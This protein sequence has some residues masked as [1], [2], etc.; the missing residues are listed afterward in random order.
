M[1]LIESEAG[2]WYVPMPEIS[3]AKQQT[4][5]IREYNHVKMSLMSIFCKS[6]KH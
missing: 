3:V 1:Q 5:T 4:H 6:L 2:E